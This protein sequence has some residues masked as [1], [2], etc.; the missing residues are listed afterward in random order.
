MSTRYIQGVSAVQ[1]M[2]LPPSLDELIPENSPVRFIGTFVDELDLV[3][4]RFTRVRPP[5]TGRPGYDPRMMLKL[6]IY[7]YVNRL[8]SSRRHA[9][10]GSPASRLPCRWRCPRW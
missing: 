8:R 4:L 10:W 1:T 3:Q 5:R 7:G 6:Y 2:L 9:P